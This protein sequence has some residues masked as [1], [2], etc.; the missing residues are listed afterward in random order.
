VSVPLHTVAAIR[1][2]I[3]AEAA[4]EFLFCAREGTD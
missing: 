1:T 2:L 4:A 3:N